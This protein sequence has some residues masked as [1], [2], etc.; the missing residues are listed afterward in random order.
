M[1]NDVQKKFNDR[2]IGYKNLE[3]PWCLIYGDYDALNE[4][5]RTAVELLNNETEN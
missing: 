2:N 5:F 1:M 3:I 4:A